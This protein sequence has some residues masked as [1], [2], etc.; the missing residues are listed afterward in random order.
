M[1]FAIPPYGFLRPREIT[2]AMVSAHPHLYVITGT[3]IGP[4]TTERGKCSRPIRRS[5]VTKSDHSPEHLLMCLRLA[6]ECNNLAGDPAVPDHRRAD[7]LRIASIWMEL[8]VLPP[9][10]APS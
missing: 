4:P 8:A 6:A 9:Q 3:V 10:D 5:T 2:F 1:R 7:Y